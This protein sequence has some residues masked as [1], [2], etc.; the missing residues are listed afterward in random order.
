MISA[1][2]HPRKEHFR[3]NRSYKQLNEILYVFYIGEKLGWSDI[4]KI[5]V[6]KCIYL[7]EILAPLKEVILFFLNFV[8]A[9]RGPYSKNI[10]NWLDYLVSLGAIEV[11]KFVKYGRSAFVNYKISESGKKVVESL[12][13]DVHEKEKYEWINLVLRV[14]DAYKD[15]S[16]IGGYKGAF[17][18]KKEFEG[19]DKIIDLVYE[20]PSFK[21]VQTKGRGEFIQM[22]VKDNPTVKLMDFL[23]N[24]EKTELPQILKKEPK[25]D[26]ETILLMFF[27]HLYLDFLSKKGE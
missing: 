25:S 16:G 9:K 2:L 15:A 11:V 18:I 12:I 27:E 17:G 13:I 21:E 10:Q 3:E 8:Y 6:Q 24:I 14:I 22:T 20:E 1:E 19:V 4:S 7:S 23:K 26:L 5:G